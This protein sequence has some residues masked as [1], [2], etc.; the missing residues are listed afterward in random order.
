MEGGA[1][2]E[3][4]SGN[5]PPPRAFLH[6]KLHYYFFYKNCDTQWV[7]AKVKDFFQNENLPNFVDFKAFKNQI[8]WMN[9]YTL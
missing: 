5:T 2:H 4:G 9:Y 7:R 1:K 3:H 8:I 6:V